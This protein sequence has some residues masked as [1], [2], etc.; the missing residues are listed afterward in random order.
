MGLQASLQCCRRKLKK[1][2]RKQKEKHKVRNTVQ[3]NGKMMRMLSWIMMLVMLVTCSSTAL[4]EIGTIESK[5]LGSVDQSLSEWYSDES[6]RAVLIA[7]TIGDISD[8]N[9]QKATTILKNALK[10]G[11]FYVGTNGEYLLMF[12]FGSKGMILSIY[13]PIYKFMTY[14]I[15]QG[16][17]A[18]IAPTALKEYKN[19]GNIKSYYEVKGVDVLEMLNIIVDAGK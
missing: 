14:E 6:M 17:N 16:L 3:L 1:N 10:N 18:S 19:G 8:C 9:D 7:G 4:A 13:D 2:L 15:F 12:I 11:K 5:F